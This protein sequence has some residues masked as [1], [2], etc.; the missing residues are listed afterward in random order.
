MRGAEKIKLLAFDVDGTLT[1][2]HLFFG[3]E[4]EAY[5]AFHV[6]DGMAM[7][8]AHDMGFITGL[9]TGRSSDIVRRRGEELHVHFL[10]MGV[11]DK[12]KALE[13]ILEKYNIS[14]KEVA[15]MGDDLND[16]PLMTKS[17]L[18]GCPADAAKEVMMAASFVSQYNGGY[19][20]VREFIEEIMK[21]RQMWD[22][23][24][25]RFSGEE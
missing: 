21:A 1:P 5:K 22:R 20:A 10:L 2:G 15:F 7:G 9:V 3:A 12:K 25:A 8:L 17:G 18:S 14:W 13:T 11:L 23:V 6:R 19:G 24:L 16:L 4:G